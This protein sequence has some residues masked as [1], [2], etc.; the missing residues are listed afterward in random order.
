M[1]FKIK[2]HIPENKLINE[3]MIGKIRQESKKSQKGF[4]WVYNNG[5]LKLKHY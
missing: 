3:K 2:Q 4:G 5:C 1:C